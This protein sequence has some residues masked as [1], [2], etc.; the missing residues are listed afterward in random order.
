M[1]PEVLPNFK[2]TLCRTGL[3]NLLN[4]NEIFPFVLTLVHGGLGNISDSRCF[5]N[6]TDHEFLD[7]LVFRRTSGTVCT[8]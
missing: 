5:D 1:L 4:K 2:N 3:V 8:P 7:G 6:I